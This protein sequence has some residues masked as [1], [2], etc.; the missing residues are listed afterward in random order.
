MDTDEIV[1][2][3][4]PEDGWWKSSTE[5]AVRNAVGTMLHNGVPPVVVEDVLEG[6]IGAVREE[7]G[8]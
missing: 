1:D 7:Y 5:D 3:L 2:K 6:L 8:D 4:T